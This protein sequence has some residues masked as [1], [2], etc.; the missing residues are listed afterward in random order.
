MSPVRIRLYGLFPVTRRRYLLQLAVAGICVV[1]LLGL[2]LLFSPAVRSHLLDQRSEAS[3][4]FL[5]FWQAL[6]W[7][8]AALAGLQLLEALIVLRRF[9]DLRTASPDPVPTPIIPPS[10]PIAPTD[11][12]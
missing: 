9:R 6:P 5:A 12:V 3:L 10:S 1:V 2:H 4:R 7:L 11:E 8:V